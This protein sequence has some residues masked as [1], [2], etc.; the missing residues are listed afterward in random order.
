MSF[1][2]EV[3]FSAYGQNHTGMGVIEAGEYG[4]GTVALQVIDT[5]GSYWSALSVCIPGTPLADNERLIKTWS[6]NE[7]LREP[8]LA[9][10]AFRDTGKRVRT[11]YVEAEIWEV[12]R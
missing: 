3:S 10:G 7:S 11:G 5:D 2:T 4:D 12:V 1:I 9:T 8:L 6:E